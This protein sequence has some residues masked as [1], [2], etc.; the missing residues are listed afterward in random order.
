MPNT[1]LTRRRVQIPTVNEIQQMESAT[2]FTEV[3]LSQGYL[4]LTLTEQSRYITAFSTSN[5]G[6]HRFT[7][8]MMGASPSGEHFHE[9]IHEL[10]R[11]IPGAANNS[12]NIWI[13]SRDK[14]THLQQLDQFLTKL[15]D[16]GIALKLPKRSFVV[17][18]INVFGHI[19][20]ANGIRPDEKKIKAVKDA[21]HPT[22]ASG[23][24]IPWPYKLLFVDSFLE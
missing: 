21:P 11:K 5:D 13:W 23:P 15:E 22:N 2:V 8:L 24:I 7:R 17:P 20:S 6:P 10:I 18:Q 4:Q 9:I 19:V 16:S 3:D 1:A 12:D 14:T